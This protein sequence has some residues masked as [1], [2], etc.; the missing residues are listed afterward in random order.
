M[1]MVMRRNLS[2]LLVQLLLSLV[3]LVFSAPNEEPIASIA[4]LCQDGAGNANR[5]PCVSCIEVGTA[6]VGF[7]L[8]TE[9]LVSDSDRDCADK[10]EKQE[11]C[12]FWTRDKTRRRC[13]LKW[14]RGDD[15]R[16]WADHVSGK[17]NCPIVIQPNTTIRVK[18]DDE[19]FWHRKEALVPNK[20]SQMSASLMV[21]A[22]NNTSKP[23]VHVYHR[24]RGRPV[25]QGI[26][27]TFGRPVS[28][29]FEGHALLVTPSLGC[30]EIAPPYSIIRMSYLHLFAVIERGECKF[31]EKVKHAQ[32][33][34]YEGAIILDNQ[35][36]SGFSRITGDD[37][38]IT[39]PVIFLLKDEA[40]RFRNMLNIEIIINVVM[41]DS[42][43]FSPVAKIKL[44][45]TDSLDPSNEAIE[46]DANPEI[47]FNPMGPSVHDRNVV[48]DLRGSRATAKWQKNLGISA[49]WLGYSPVMI[50]VFVVIAV[51]ILLLI[52]TTVVY[53]KHCSS[54]YRRR[55]QRR[56]RCQQAVREMEAHYRNQFSQKSL[57]QSRPIPSVSSSSA[58]LDLQQTAKLLECPVCLE[59][60]WPPRKIFQC[61]QGHI[62]CDIC[63]SHP[64]LTTC[65]ICRQVLNS[66]YVSRNLAL[67]NLA[68]NLLEQAQEGMLTP[69]LPRPK[70]T[71]S[72]TTLDIHSVDSDSNQ[73]PGTPSAPSMED[74]LAG[75]A[76]ES[77]SNHGE[78]LEDQTPLTVVLPPEN[79]R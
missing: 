13:Y 37:A 38:S 6:Y 32:E 73:A 39:I 12:Q 55:Q 19:S 57:D 74:I 7:N 22:P 48:S 78:D 72:H 23:L 47:R 8:L 79:S 42:K 41:E 76:V 30:E 58:V 67:E 5:T 4:P 60:S 71:S 33:A 62:I 21:P 10:C 20:T 59:T 11:K 35:D 28:T 24:G 63:K 53:V 66:R 56:T 61:M 14:S 77:V 18:K 17:W 68:V 3:G 69:S 16:S 26:P 36:H 54:R 9:P 65:P 34:G 49:E 44:Q 27:A 15:I 70:R 52:I 29:H 45:K 46:V 64:Q 51:L 50:S 2:L 31:I 25:L 1:N 43:F 40:D 75:I